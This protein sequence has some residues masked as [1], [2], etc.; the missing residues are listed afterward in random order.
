MIEDLL[1]LGLVYHTIKCA[2]DDISPTFDFRGNLPLPYRSVSGEERDEPLSASEIDK[3]RS[4]YAPLDEVKSTYRLMYLLGIGHSEEEATVLSEINES[5]LDFALHREKYPGDSLSFK[6][7]K[8]CGELPAQ[9]FS[10]WDEGKEFLRH[11]HPKQIS[12][13]ESISGN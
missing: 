3:W 9:R 4:Q 1:Q 5:D 11:E 6:K 12:Y 8:L 13:M 10:S 2:V 7:I